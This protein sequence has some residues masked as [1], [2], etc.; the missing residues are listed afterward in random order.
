MIIIVNEKKRAH[1]KLIYS[2][3]SFLILILTGIC[4][5]HFN[6]ISYLKI[7]ERS[8]ISANPQFIHIAPPTPT[9]VPTPSTNLQSIIQ[10]DIQ[11]QNATFGVAIKDL[12][13][14][15]FYSYNGDMQFTAASIYK[16]SVMYTIFKLGNEGKINLNSSQVKN[17]L[18]WMITVSS[19]DATLDLVEQFTTWKEITSNDHALGMNSTDYTGEPLVTTPHDT[20]KLVELIAT[21]KAI[22]A[23]ASAQMYQLMLGQTIQDRIPA[24]LPPGAIVANK[25][26]DLDDVRH[27]AA[28]VTSPH[29]KFIIVIMTKNSPTPES[30]KPVIAQIALD[31][32]NYLD[33]E[34]AN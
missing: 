27:D 16:L 18:K 32:Y 15:E 1:K 24:K 25:T 20:E 28:I 29:T 10:K 22:N 5:V 8:L 23:T 13:T 9:P 26:G 21:G 34:E 6:V 31:V 7:S 19:N 3:F 33:S 17:D 4:F 11:G 14:G 12:D 2:T 30:N